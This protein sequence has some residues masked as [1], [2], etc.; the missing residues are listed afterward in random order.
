MKAL[1]I[2]A[3]LA[4]LPVS[5]IGICTI[6]SKNYLAYARVLAES[7]LAHNLG[8][9]FIL[10]T[11]KVDGYF[12][13]AKEKF[14]LIEMEALKNRVPDFERFCF[15]LTFYHLQLSSCQIYIQ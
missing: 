8:Q 4:L 6:I 11:D 14:T 12:V 2:G 1:I 9:V 5:A 13:P 7:Y 3:V 15:H 10:L